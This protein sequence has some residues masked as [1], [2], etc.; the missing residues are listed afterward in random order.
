MYK[1]LHLSMNLH[2]LLQPNSLS[3]PIIHKTIKT[4]CEIIKENQIFKLN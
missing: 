2:L 4:A 3:I 1:F